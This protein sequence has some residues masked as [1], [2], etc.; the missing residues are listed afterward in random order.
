MIQDT[1]HLVVL[2]KFFGEDERTGLLKAVNGDNSSGKE[3]SEEFWER[4]TADGAHGSK[5]WGLKA[6]RLQKLSSEPNE[7][8]LEIQSRLVR[9]NLLVSLFEVYLNKLEP[10]I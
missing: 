6:K 4:N 5:T 7:A 1:A 2:D 10:E 9:V 8:I 3:L